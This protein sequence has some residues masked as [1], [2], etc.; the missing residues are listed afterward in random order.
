ME[1]LNPGVSLPP[2]TERLNSRKTLILQRQ[3]ILFSAYRSDQYSDPEGYVASLQMV[4]EQY[5]NDVIIHVTDPRTGV[6]RHL[7]WP[8]SIAEIIEACDKRMQEKARLER[9]QNPRR[10]VPALGPPQE[11]RPTREEMIAKYGE[12]WGLDPV[13]P[14]RAPERAPSWDTIVAEYRANPDRIKRLA[15][16]ADEEPEA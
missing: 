15:R 1:K 5:P 12:N 4:L 3:R 8:P 11:A 9:L 13:T 16:V 7:K 10:E 14:K 6:Q 2:S